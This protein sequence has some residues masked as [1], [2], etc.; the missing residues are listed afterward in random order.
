MQPWR[1]HGSIYTP[2]RSF[3]LPHLKIKHTLHL[4][5]I[6]HHRCSLAA[7]TIQISTNTETTTI[8]ATT[9]ELREF[10]FPPALLPDVWVDPE[11]TVTV[12][13]G[14]VELPSQ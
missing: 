2:F 1:M 13:V 8:A 11:S 7:V 14:D 5:F 12:T 4:R 3:R 6:H 10:E 9:P